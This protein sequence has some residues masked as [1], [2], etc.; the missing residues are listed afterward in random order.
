MQLDL[1][2]LITNHEL[3]CTSLSATKD[4]LG[5]KIDQTTHENKAEAHKQYAKA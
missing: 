2:P 5:D 1:L 3:I 4:A